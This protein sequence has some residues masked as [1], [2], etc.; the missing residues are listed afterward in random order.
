MTA[1]QV[2]YVGDD[3]PDAPIMRRVGLA[4]AVGDAWSEAKQCAHYIT[5][6][7]G[8]RG[9]VREVVELIL[10][11]QGKWDAAIDRYVNK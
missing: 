2:A 8:G 11:T 7:P 10:K 4:I 9:A 3:L 1:S 5:S 6:M